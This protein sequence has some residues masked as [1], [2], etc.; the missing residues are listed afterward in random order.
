M[1]KLKKIIL[2]SGLCGALSIVDN[3]LEKQPAKMYAGIGYMMSKKGYSAEAGLAVS[4]AGIAHSAASSAIYGAVFGGFA[5][6]A[7]GAVIGA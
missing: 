1:S 2:L 6:A 4:V 3:F 5:G 7:A